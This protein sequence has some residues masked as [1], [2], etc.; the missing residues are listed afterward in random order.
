MSVSASWNASFIQ[1]LTGSLKHATLFYSAAQSCF[2]VRQQE[3]F[4][5]E[6]RVLTTYQFLFS[7]LD[8]KQNVVM[9]TAIDHRRD[10]VNVHVAL[11]HSSRTCSQNEFF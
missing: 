1:Q 4:E 6:I 2:F 9:D 5:Y 8:F 3:F 10:H 11:A 7:F